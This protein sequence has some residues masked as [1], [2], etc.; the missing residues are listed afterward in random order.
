MDQAIT[1]GRTK[2]EKYLLSK[3]IKQVD[4]VDKVNKSFPDEPISSDTMSRIVSGNREIGMKTL[5]RLCKALDLTPNDIL[6]I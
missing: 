1:I 5:R 2:L 3:K 4:L 6:D